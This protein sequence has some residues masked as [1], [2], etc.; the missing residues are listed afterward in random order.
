MSQ[1]TINT[2]VT[3]GQTVNVPRPDNGAQIAITSSAGG[4]L[5]LG[6]DPGAATARP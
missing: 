1:A 4:V 3:S 2:T 5:D 6:F